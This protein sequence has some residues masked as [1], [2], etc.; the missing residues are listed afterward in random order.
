MTQTTQNK[1]KQSFKKYLVYAVMIIIFAGCLW[2]IFAPSGKDKEAQKQG[3]GF[4]ADIPDPRG[5]DIVSDKKTA[6]E[7][8]QVRLRQEEKMKSLEEHTILLGATDENSEEYKR[9]AG[10]GPV[11][12]DYQEQL[13]AEREQTSSG[14]SS[15]YG[16][17]SG[18]RSNSFEATGAAH[19]DLT[20]T[21]GSFY[22][23]PKEDAEKEELRRELEELKAAGQSQQSAY[24]DQL[25]LLEKSFELAAKYN[26]AGMQ[27]GLSQG[28]GSGTSYGSSPGDVSTSNG[29]TSGSR[30]NVEAVTQVKSN[31][32]SSLSQPMTDS[33]FIE[34]YSQPRNFGFN[35]VSSAGQTVEKNTIAAVVHGDQVIVDGQGVRLRLTEPMRAGRH[36]IPRNTIITGIGHIGGERL[37]ISISSIEYAGTIIPV[38][39]SAY[40]PDGQRG[41]YVPSSMELNAV[42]EIAGNIGQSLGTTINLNQQSAGEQLLTDM[43]RGAIQGTSQLISKKVKQVKITLKAGYRILLLPSENL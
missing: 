9:Q 2:L 39:L 15:D 33:E 31:V 16:S 5:A 6:Y 24:D 1:S 35:T 20:A 12:I 29:N 13:N 42:K 32:V 7:Q 30:A 4:N 36:V 25:V 28:A 26:T 40:D 8:E 22:E 27:P 17:Y 11:P 43:G 14:Y 41:I 21:L 18:R 19:A 3:I 34:Q 38:E 23:E 37:E 10:K